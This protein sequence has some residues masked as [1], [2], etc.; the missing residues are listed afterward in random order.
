MESIN[1][2]E[3]LREKLA[4]LRGRLEEA[5]RPDTAALGFPGT[6][7][8]A[9]HCAAVS[10]IVYEMLGGEMISTLVE[11][12]SHWLN[13]LSVAGR[14]LDVDVTGD[15]FGRP[16]LQIAEAGHLY[17]DTRVR[18]RDDL[19][20]ETLARARILAERAGLEEAARAIARQAGRR[21]VRAE[22]R[23]NQGA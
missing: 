18:V 7:P 21:S 17:P 20:D 11:G 19:A 16:Q 23:R 6:A 10:A 8:S 13:R 14:A 5:F 4:T 2:T 15:Q 3:A 1:E 22:A 9:G 12:H